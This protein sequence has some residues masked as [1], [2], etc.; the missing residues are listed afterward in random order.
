MSRQG[1]WEY[2]QRKQPCPYCSKPMG[3]HN[4]EQVIECINKWAERFS[5]DNVE[6]LLESTTDYGRPETDMP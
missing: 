4:E 5:K 2:I 1:Y 6:T 3:E